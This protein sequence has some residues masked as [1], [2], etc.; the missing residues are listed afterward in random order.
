M[1]SLEEI[2]LLNIKDKYNVIWN[3]ESK[4]ISKIEILE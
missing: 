3:V 4:F 2:V 1:L